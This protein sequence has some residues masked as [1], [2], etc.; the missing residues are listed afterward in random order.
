[1]AAQSQDE[2]VSR[3]SPNMSIL[4]SRYNI[5]QHIYRIG[6]ERFSS[7]LKAVATGSFHEF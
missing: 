4:L 5:R 7:H 6:W 2:C 1:M 3:S